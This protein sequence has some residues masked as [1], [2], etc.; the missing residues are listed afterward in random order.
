MQLIIECFVGT[1]LNYQEISYMSPEPSESSV[2]IV[3]IHCLLIYFEYWLRIIGQRIFSSLG[4]DDAEI[5]YFNINKV[6]KS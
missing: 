5:I 3:N 6:R 4:M 2:L 1:T